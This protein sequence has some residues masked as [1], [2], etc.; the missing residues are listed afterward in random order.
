MSEQFNLDRETNISN[1]IDPAGKK[2]EVHKRLG[3]ALFH[4]RPNPDRE[5]AIIPKE[6]EGKW[7]KP[8]ILD[9]A[10]DLYLKRMWDEAEAQAVKNA[11]ANE[12]AKEAAKEKAAAEAEAAR[13]LEIKEACDKENAE[14]A[15]AALKAATPVK[16]SEGR[17]KKGK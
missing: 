15:A 7:T 2:W 4:I 14:I 16:T 9:E 11:R 1:H 8:K 13:I 17:V 12:L 10:R 3:Q 5:D 6:M